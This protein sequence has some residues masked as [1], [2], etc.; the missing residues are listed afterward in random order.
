MENGVEHQPSLLPART[1][2][3]VQSRSIAGLQKLVTAKY[4]ATMRFVA[5]EALIDQSLLEKELWL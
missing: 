2:N 4:S 1:I 3:E 5:S